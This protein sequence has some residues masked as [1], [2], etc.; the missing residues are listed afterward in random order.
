MTMQHSASDAVPPRG[1]GA[2]LLARLDQLG[3]LRFAVVFTLGLLS[4]GWLVA[5]LATSFWPHPP[6]FVG[7]GNNAIGRDFLAPYAAATLAIAGDPS[8]AYDDARLQAAERQV[9]G[10]P[11]TPTPFL[12]PPSFLLVAAPLAFLPYLLALALWLGGQVF[13]FT[14]FLRRLMPAPL[15]PW[16]ALLFPATAE[17]LIAG[18]NG[19]LSA[20]LLAGG[21]CH[22]E[23]RPVVAGLLFG[24]LSY[25]PHLAA[26]AFVAL[27][28]GAHWRALAAALA[29]ALALILA[30]A[31]IL[32]LAPWQAFL[33][34]LGTARGLLESGAL[35]WEKLVTP[36]AAARLLGA[37]V[38][39]AW[40]VQTSIA[41]IAIGVLIHVWR[42]RAPLAWRGSVLAIVMPLVTPYAFFYDLVPLFLP[43]AWLTASSEANGWR[44]GEGLI[45][46]LGWVSPV[47]G[48]LL[49]GQSHLLLPPV[50]IALLLVAVLRRAPA[51]EPS[52]QPSP[53]PP[54]G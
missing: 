44:R 43:L 2:S 48:L 7:P 54:P 4:A 51:G 3:P 46:A 11:A 34:Q 13:F 29:A 1:P 25:K 18:Q 35:S 28:F 22:L 24:A 17:S 30:S 53:E 39:T 16:A 23:R 31:I 52:R 38:A 42:R 45:V 41:L 5:G 19:V 26:A 49:A 6:G 21:L 15:T 40:L 9:I 10:A 27:L 14:R 50:I 47:T 20:T 12:Y 36:F 33:G 32:G 8:A 37:S